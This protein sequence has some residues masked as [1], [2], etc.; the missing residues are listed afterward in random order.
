MFKRKAKSKK[1]NHPQNKRLRNTAKQAAEQPIYSEIL[2]VRAVWPGK[3]A[4]SQIHLASN[5]ERLKIAEKPSE[6]TKELEEKF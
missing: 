3:N 5:C 2:F 6:G 1:K 4:F